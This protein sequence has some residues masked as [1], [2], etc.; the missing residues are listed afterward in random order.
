MRWLLRP[1]TR[2]ARLLILRLRVR[3]L[4][5]GDDFA[6]LY[7][8][9]DATIYGLVLLLPGDT[10]GGAASFS[11]L[12]RLFHGDVGLGLIF[13]ALAAALWL[14]ALRLIPP[15]GQ[16]CVLTATF[17]AWVGMSVGFFAG[18]PWS[19]GPWV[20]LLNALAAWIA[21]LRVDHE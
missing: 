17:A 2:H 4:R 10:T 5:Y 11:V 20:A 14:S 8:A 18:Y 19:L 15:A 6:E 1:D 9:L 7:L 3:T 16:R 21:Y 13:S 12:A